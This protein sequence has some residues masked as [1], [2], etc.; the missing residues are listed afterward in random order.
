MIKFIQ[1]AKFYMPIIY[2]T[3]GM[4]IYFIIANTIKK[5]SKINIKNLKKI[6]ENHDKKKVTVIGLINNIIKYII[7]IIVVILILN[8]YG[9]NTTSIIASLGAISLIIGLAFQDIIKDL[10]AGIFIIL[11][12]AYTVGDVVEIKGFKGEIISLGLKTTKI[13]SYTGEVKII[14]NSSFTE[15]INYNLNH[16][17]VIINIPFSYNEKIEKIESA[18]NKVKEYIETN[19]DVYEME[20]LGIDEFA[21]SSINYAILIECGPMKHIGIKREVLKL[22]KET[23]D[24]EKIEIPY[25]QIDIHMKD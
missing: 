9:V 1:S 3:S 12:N 2:I 5:L 22:I 19:K 25:N 11:D 13:K 8:I 6:D 17:K 10:L 16:S 14:S 15:V 18:L 4:I 20:L 23:F 7:V 21:E 24:Q